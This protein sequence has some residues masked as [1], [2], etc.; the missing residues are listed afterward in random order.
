MDITNGDNDERFS[1]WEGGRFFIHV[2]FLPD[3]FYSCFL[4][5][6]HH[7]LSIKRFTK[8]CNCKVNVV[9]M[10]SFHEVWG[11]KATVTNVDSVWCHTNHRLC[12]TFQIVKCYCFIL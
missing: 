12:R 5:R 11:E 7:D 8:T 6:N 9:S 2:K 4:E 3:H 1:V 10:V